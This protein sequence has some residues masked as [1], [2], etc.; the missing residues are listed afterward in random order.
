[1]RVQASLLASSCFF[2]EEWGISTD[3]LR[4]PTLPQH[5]YFHWSIFIFSTHLV[6]VQKKNRVLSSVG[7]LCLSSFYLQMRI[8]CFTSTR[9]PKVCIL[10]F[11]LPIPF[12]ST[13]PYF[14]FLFF[15]TFSPSLLTF[16]IDWLLKMSHP[17]RQW[18]KMAAMGV[19]QVSATE[20]P[21][22]STVA[23]SLAIAIRYEVQPYFY[24]ASLPH[25]FQID[26]WESMHSKGT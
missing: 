20:L 14:F 2:M 12:F 5:W 21:P 23:L 17:V 15:F 18:V 8:L 10:F 25:P 16:S 26:P 22:L 9:H 4:P 24:H 7:F 13:C 1:M 19:K 11:L 3:P 6:F